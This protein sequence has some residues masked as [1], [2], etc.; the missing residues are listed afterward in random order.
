M[1][2]YQAS[3]LLSSLRKLT[4]GQP[5]MR[6]LSSVQ[7]NGDLA[8]SQL[9]Q[10]LWIKENT[11]RWI[12]RNLGPSQLP[13]R[14]LTPYNQFVMNKLPEIREMCP[15][16]TMPGTMKRIGNEWR[17]V[18]SGRKE[19]MKVHYQEELARWRESLENLPFEVKEEV[20]ERV[21]EEKRLRSIN[22]ASRELKVPTIILQ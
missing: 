10:N 22:A 3:G 12:S 13:K 20:R 1:L 17:K 7:P 16:L 15:E 4:C 19:A 8:L 14:P 2:R 21:A 5:T 11:K 18:P 6:L 9:M